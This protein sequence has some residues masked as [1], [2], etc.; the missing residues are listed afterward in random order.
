MTEYLLDTCA[1]VWT[2]QGDPLREP[3][4][5]ELPKSLERGARLLVSPIT[6]WEVATLVAKG[7]N[8]PRTQP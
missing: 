4:A 5:T 1:V 8:G 6:A 7:K 3:A 2:A